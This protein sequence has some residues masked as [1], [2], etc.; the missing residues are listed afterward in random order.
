L[1]S[2]ER[3]GKYRLAYP[4]K[5][6]EYGVYFL[7]RFETEDASS[8]PKDVALM[9]KVKFSVIVMRDMTTRLDESATLVYQRPPSLE[10]APTR[11]VK[12]FLRDNKMESL[13]PSV[14]DKAASQ[15]VDET[16]E[17]FEMDSA[18]QEASTS[19]DEE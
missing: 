6:N 14:E 9:C 5:K 11:D 4:V 2:Y 10:D 16:V 15:K 3:W 7:A 18:L 13:I 12:T 1:I 17:E 8:L 19:S